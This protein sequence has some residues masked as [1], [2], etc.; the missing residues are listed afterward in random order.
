[1]RRKNK[2]VH[3][4]NRG[5]ITNTITRAPT[6][7][8]VSTNTYCNGKTANAKPRNCETVKPHYRKTVTATATATATAATGTGTAATGTAATGTAAAALPQDLFDARPLAHLD[9]FGARDHTR[10]EIVED[11]LVDQQAR[12]RRVCARARVC[13]CV[14]V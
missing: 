9:G 6:V 1:V 11:I 4:T 10:H 8:N 13:V 5:H 3:H 7:T 2:H 14:S 12:L